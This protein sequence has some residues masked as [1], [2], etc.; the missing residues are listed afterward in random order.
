MTGMPEHQGGV[1]PPGSFEGVE[2]IRLGRK[3]N[4]EFLP[5][6]C[7]RLTRSCARGAPDLKSQWLLHAH[8]PRRYE[9]KGVVRVWQGVFSPNFAQTR[10]ASLSAIKR[11]V[12]VLPPMMEKNPGAPSDA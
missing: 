12:V 2:H 1:L 11:A 7:Y 5:V 4:L 10:S 9:I 3:G 6:A 8:I